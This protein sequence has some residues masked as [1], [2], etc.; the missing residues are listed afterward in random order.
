MRCPN[1]PLT[2]PVSTLLHRLHTDYSSHLDSWH[3]RCELSN[4]HRPDERHL[5]DVTA[6][7]NR[8][9]NV[10]LQGCMSHR[11]ARLTSTANSCQHIAVWHHEVWHLN[12]L[13]R[14]L[15]CSA[16]T[17]PSA[18]GGQ[19]TSQLLALQAQ[20]SPTP[21]WAAMIPADDTS[22]EDDRS[23]PYRQS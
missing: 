13:R 11:Q 7:L 19:H 17:T 21:R 6:P 1:P 8:L 18:T 5:R 14:I 9:A 4:R 20:P 16:D 22:D 12:S 15:C 23:W 3:G 2:T 10:C